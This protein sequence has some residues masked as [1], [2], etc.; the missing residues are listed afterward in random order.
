MAGAGSKRKAGQPDESMSLLLGKLRGPCQ[1]KKQSV[2]PNSPSCFSPFAS[3][4]LWERL[5]QWRSRFAD[6]HKL[7]QDRFATRMSKELSNWSVIFS[8]QLE[9]M[10]WVDLQ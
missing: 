5:Q 4:D 7:D 9:G 2:K 3:G 10:G 6:L 8:R 1:C